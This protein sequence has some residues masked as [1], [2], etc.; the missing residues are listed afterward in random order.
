MKRRVLSWLL[1]AAMLLT[2]L[3][4]ALVRAAEG[5]ELAFEPLDITSEDLNLPAPELPWTQEPDITPDPEE[6]VK[7]IILLEE[8]SVLQADAKAV[9]DT[10]G[11]L[12][13]EGIK[14]RQEPVLETIRQDV[15]GGRS[16]QVD[17]RYSWLLNGVAAAVPYGAIGEIEQ[18]EGVQA[19]VLQQLY[20]VCENQ[21]PP[22]E[23][24]LPGE[25]IIGREAA[26]AAGYTGKGVRIAVIDTGL[27]SDHPSFAPLGVEKLTADSATPETVAGVLESLNAWNRCADLRPEQL[28]RSTKVAFGFNYCDNNT[29]IDHLDNKGD[30]GTHVAGIAA[31]NRLPGIRVAGVAPDAQLYIMKVF[32]VNGGAYSQ[33]I[34]A[35]LEDALLLDADVINL[36]LGTP[37]GFPSAERTPQGNLLDALYNRISS[38]GT[39]LSVS[40]GNYYNSGYA[41]R[42]G[43]NTNLSLYPDNG[44]VG[45]PASYANTMTVASAESVTV[46]RPYIDAE[47]IHLPYNEATNADL[48]KLSTLTGTYGLMPITMYGSAADYAGLDLTGK[49]ALVYR[50][51]ISFLEKH[52]AAEAA[53]A[54]ALLVINSAEDELTMDLSG[55]GGTIPAASLSG[56]NGGILWKALMADSALQLSFPEEYGEFISPQAYEM[57]DFS[58][59][60]PGADLSLT[61]DIAAPGGSIY[62]S[63]DGGGYGVMSGTSMAAPGMA[64]MAALV[65]QYVREEL[66]EDT[67]RRAAVQNL[68]GSTAMKL[69][70]A[71]DSSLPFSPR[72][73]GAGLVNVYHALISEGCLRVEG[74]DGVKAELGDDPEKT[75]SYFFAFEIQNFSDKDAYYSV[76]TMVLSEE[77]IHAQGHTF[78]S[79]SP[80]LLSAQTGE[81]ASAMIPRYDVDDSGKLDIRDAGRIWQTVRNNEDPGEFFFRYDVNADQKVSSE[82]V[83]AMLDHL[84]GNDSDAD[85]AAGMVKVAPGQTARVDVSISLTPED[86]QYL[87]TYFPNGGYVEGYTTLQALHE[88]GVNLSIP[89]LG[90]YGDWAQAPVLDT[91]SYWD[92]LCAPEGEVVGNQ[93]IHQLYSQFRGEKKAI[94]PGTNPYVTD[95]PFSRENICLSPNGDGNLDSLSEINLSLLRNAASLELRFTNAATGELLSSASGGSISKSV[96]RSDAGRVVPYACSALGAKALF[97]FENLQSGDVVMLEARVVGVAENA[98]PETWSVSIA[99]DLEAPELLQALRYTDEATGKTLLALRFRENRAAAAVILADG[100]HTNVLALETAGTPEAREE[101]HN[102]Y[103]KCFDITGLSGKLTVILGDYAANERAYGINL[104]GEGVPYG[105]LLAFQRNFTKGTPCWV[106]FNRDVQRSEIPLFPETA[107]EVSSAAYAEGY[108]YAQREN[109]ELIRFAGE[110]ILRDKAAP[111][112][113]L[114]QTLQRSYLDLTWD[115]VRKVLYGLYRDEALGMTQVYALRYLAENG[116]AAL[117]QEEL[118]LENPAIT[119]FCLAADNQGGLYILGTEAESREAWLWKLEPEQGAGQFGP[120]SAWTD[121]GCLDKKLLER[122][123]MTFDSAAGTLL[124]ARFDG[125]MGKTICQLV[126]IFPGESLEQTDGRIILK[127]NVLGELSGQTLGLMLP[128]YP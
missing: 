65:L 24:P 11:K 81:S 91:G 62:S 84:V 63:V 121:L 96:Y 58:A 15:L 80:R 9:L 113:E 128:E 5:E 100:T 92:Q 57:S 41:N 14:K 45:A 117:W 29:V 119:G 36:S 39:V 54:V 55:S 40:A 13:M 60:G 95:E 48:P 102:I 116:D 21:Q 89:F 18:L 20:A 107:A 101:D 108:V 47:G 87:D 124:W 4:G 114:L 85:S 2:L 86:R 7:V 17:Y 112:V 103:T 118:L 110:D 56:I 77:V 10:S 49:V 25:D 44:V 34:L 32:G 74:A 38:T 126:E 3:P 8:K 50:G 67:D 31:A 122:Q 127:T 12:R 51:G 109:G 72:Y 26:W 73:Q 90:F 59:W 68:L 106:S 37:A 1:C 64:G 97:D 115:P 78:L 105:E 22:E 93:G 27:D 66:P 28:Y 88:G 71:K 35:A 98:A 125:E 6:M 46:S 23:L 53:G 120:D 70:Y 82:D 16:F 111:E 61:P 33:D 43:T 69:M 19:V 52:R 30:H 123:S 75:G 83:Q 79:G 99:I 104:A 76:N 42:W 94:L